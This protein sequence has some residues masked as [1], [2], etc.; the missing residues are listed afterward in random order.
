MNLRHASDSE[1][2][3]HD[4]RPELLGRRAFA[5]GGSVSGFIQH[6]AV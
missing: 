3:V 1:L 2:L 5:H 4:V 6:Q